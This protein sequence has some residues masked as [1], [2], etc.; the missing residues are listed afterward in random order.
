MADAA[1]GAAA[2]AGAAA[3]VSSQVLASAP[4]WFA[5]LLLSTA[6]VSVSVLAPP[7]YFVEP[8]QLFPIWP[9]WRTQWAFALAGATAFLLFVPKLLAAALAWARDRGG[10]GGAS[11]LALSVLAE[12]ALSALLAPI[13]MLFHTQF[14]AGALAGRRAAWKSPPRDDSETRWREA[15]AR[16]GWHTLLGCAW[17]GFVYWL[18]PPFLWWLVPVAGALAL[19]IPLSVLT[20]RISAGKRRRRARVFLIPEEVE[21][22]PELARVRAAVCEARPLPRFADAVRDPALNALMCAAAPARARRAQL[23]AQ[24]G[25][26]PSRDGN[27]PRGRG[28]DGRRGYDGCRG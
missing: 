7:P 17:A 24:E 16:H 9:E 22:P 3:S 26:P 1:A 28:Y 18:E 12:F 10:C 5:S 21:P 25:L 2:G 6:L 4:S 8:H 14:V 23:G 20:S 19:S 27:V 11:R 15:F 13:R